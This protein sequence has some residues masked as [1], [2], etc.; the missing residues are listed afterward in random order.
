MKKQYLAIALSM[1]IADMA[2]A[3]TVD[4][5]Q[6]K[7]VLDAVVV[8]GER[9]NEPEQKLAG[10]VD[11]IS[12]EELEYERVDDTSELFNKVPGVYLSRYNQGLINSD[13]S[14]RGFAGDGETPHAK[15]LIDGIPSNLH[16]GTSEMDQLFPLG[17]ESITVFK[18]T[19]DPTVGPYNIAGNYRL[20]SRTDVDTTQLEVSLGS[21]SAKE[22]QFYS[23]IDSGA[24]QHNYFAGYR[25]SNGYRDN[26]NL[27]KYVLSGRWKFAPGDNTS[28]TVIARAS[29]YE[30]DAPGYLTLAE[31]RAAPRSSA[32]YANQDGGSKDIQHFSAH[33]DH[34][35]GDNVDW[36]LKAYWQEYE[37]E[38]WVRFSQAGALQ[39]RFD[40][41]QHY[42]LLSSL[43]WRINDQWQFDVGVDAEFQDVIE[44]RFGT[45]GQQR[46]RDTNNVLRNR[47]FDFETQ[48]AYVRIAQQI[49]G[50]F[51]WNLAL[52][53]D[54]LDG[55]YVQFSATG[56]PSARNI[57]NFGTIVQPKLN[58]FAKAGDSVT[59]FANAGRSFQH[60]FSA[61]A[62]TLGNRDARD[63]SIND[64]WEAGL[65]W[66]PSTEFE[67]RLSHWQQKAKDEFVVVDGTAQ[68]V[69]ETQRK[70]W[71]IAAN[72]YI[73][74]RFYLWAN[75]TTVD[76]EITRPA[77]SQRN[78]IGNELRG[79]PG[80]TGSLGFTFDINE[81]FSWR[82]HVD[83]QG[84]Y[85]VNEAN[86]GGQFGEYTLAH[87]NLDYK[88][89]W[90]K[91]ALQI[92]NIFDRY[93]DYVFDFSTNGTGTIHSPGDGRSYS[94][95]VGFDW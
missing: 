56:V 19:S 41:Q 24:L 16:A 65:K 45:I 54:R 11:V 78:F 73:T 66:S 88:T 68:N 40:D 69:G 29:G 50:R 26:T 61:E 79:I 46:I 67:L 3:Q 85:F 89:D 87:T 36:S 71:D 25:K 31:S 27:D 64:G 72:W 10:S 34:Q 60:P 21:Y 14:I 6:A 17:I 58:V 59:L 49:N 84:S 33:L 22:L 80:H 63:V 94:L 15:L 18:G 70:G 37:R 38:R 90:G 52:R 30:G 53:A 9:S 44:Q 55:D 42:G 75:Y 32:S 51:G 12:R 82:M 39:N 2:W 74:E 77:D 57:Y 5:G 81:K 1:A 43:L 4:K 62:F 91:I 7:P 76:S 92:N 28:L 83:R 35:F 47:D 20:R 23:G 93:Y 86:L 48:G 13:I 95:T 8:I